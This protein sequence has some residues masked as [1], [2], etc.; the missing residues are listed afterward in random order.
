MY[1]VIMAGGSGT[2]FWP[3]SRRDRPKQFLAIGTDRPLL[4]ETVARLDPLVPLERILVVAGAHHADTIRALLPGLPP[5]N[6]LIE[7]CARN[8]APCVGLA[9]AH[10][11]ARDPDAVMAVLPADHHI[12]DP[13]RFRALIAAAADRA[14]RGEIVTLGIRPTRPETGYG[15][16]HFDRTDTVDID[17]VA[18]CRVERF[19]EKP[20]REVAE[21]YLASGRYLWNSG[22][23]FFTPRRILAD[24]G[25]FLPATRARLDRIAAAI[26]TPAYAETLEREFAATEAVSLDYGVMEHADRVRVVPAAFGWNDV[27][28]W[29][30]LADFGDVDDRGNVLRGDTVIVD[31]HGCVVQSEGPLVALV[32]VHD[33]VVVATGDAVLVCPKDRAQDVRRVVDRLAARKREDVL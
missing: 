5:D 25:R 24:I 17:G 31:S 28:H 30:A 32:G 14:R 18:A 12:G 23:F 13:A 3:V 2:R 11:A 19:V 1:A 16:I 8:T 15:Y 29:A 7:P 26:G 27:G 20:P 21:Q 22:M 33:L 10:L 6:L 4:V 9:A